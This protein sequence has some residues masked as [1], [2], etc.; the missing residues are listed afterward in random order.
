MRPLFFA[1]RYLILI[2]VLG[3]LLCTLAVFIFGGI[4]TITIVFEAFRHGAFNSEG[5]RIFSA[6]LIELIDLFLLGT[7][8]LITSMGLYE[9][10]IDPAI[11]LPTWLS[12]KTLDHLKMN[13]VAV[14]IVMLTVLF[15]GEAATEWREG[16]TILEFGAGIA[17]I[18]TAASLA[19][20][21][22]QRVHLAIHAAAHVEAHAP[23]RHETERHGES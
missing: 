3:L 12:V 7:V 5:A 14:L 22:F 18:I 13:L 4:T 6:E 21:I 19:V 8:L 10:F 11:P 1:S 23:E 9:L 15:L 2:A 17:L 20:F 16:Q